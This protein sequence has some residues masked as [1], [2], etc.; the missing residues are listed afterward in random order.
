MA[1]YRRK[2]RE[3]KQKRVR[4]IKTHH[5]EQYISVY[6]LIMNNLANLTNTT[7]EQFLV[8]TGADFRILG[9]SANICSLYPIIC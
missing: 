5:G 1:V 4:F 6:M 2:W 3:M 9:W 7:Y 8:R